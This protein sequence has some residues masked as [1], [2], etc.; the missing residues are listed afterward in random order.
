MRRGSAGVGFAFQMLEDFSNEARL[1]DEGNHTQL[2][3]TRTQKW[4]ELEDSS[5]E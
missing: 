2:A 1:G 5:D 4:V 3:A